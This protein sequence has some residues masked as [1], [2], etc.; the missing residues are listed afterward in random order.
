M[1]LPTIK[2]N[3]SSPQSTHRCHLAAAA[4]HHVLVQ[5]VPHLLAHII[6]AQATTVPAGAK[7]LSSMALT[8]HSTCNAG[9]RG[10]G[11]RHKDTTAQQSEQVGYRQQSE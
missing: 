11:T 7:A 3:L 9:E 10:A 8:Q 6:Q 2:H 5:S 4:C 1:T